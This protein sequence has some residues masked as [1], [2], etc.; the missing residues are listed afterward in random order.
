MKKLTVIGSLNVDQYHF[1]REL[2]RPGETITAI[3]TQTSRGG[4]GA[5]QA[6][7][8]ARAGAS[9]S[10]IGMTGADRAGVEYIAA[11]QAE[12]IHTKGISI[13]PSTSTGSAFISVDS[14]GENAIIVS[15]GANANLSPEYLDTYRELITSADAILLQFET[16]MEIVVRASEI[17]AEAGVPVFLN[18]S[19]MPDEVPWDRLKISTVIVNEAEYAKLPPD[20]N[21]RI[22]VTRGSG[23]TSM[24]EGENVISVPAF[25][26][27]PLDTVGAGDTFAGAVVTALTEG[28]SATEALSFANAA[29]ALATLAPGAQEAI[30]TR[31]EIVLML[32]R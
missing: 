14:K 31:V 20:I 26:V 30:P 4:K 17:A 23:D 18:P 25:K 22:I 8:A 11:L 9:V 29:G 2:P 24:I 13:D 6:L 7:A 12:G 1:V 3:R 27:T 15:A 28:M 10:M 5:N 19:P 16:P 32:G 21:A